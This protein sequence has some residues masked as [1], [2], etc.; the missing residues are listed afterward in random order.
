MNKL[1]L[2]KEVEIRRIEGSLRSSESF[3]VTEYKSLKVSDLEELRAKLRP[4]F[5]E[6]RVCKNRLLKIASNRAGL[7]GLDDFLTGQNLFIFSKEGGSQVA[8][9]LYDFSRTNKQLVLKAG[10]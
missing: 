8:K 1:R 3:F 5:A 4:L 6:V 9:Q 10:L 7:T 2:Q